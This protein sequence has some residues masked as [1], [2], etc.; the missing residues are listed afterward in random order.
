M[1]LSTGRRR[2][3]EMPPSLGVGFNPVRFHFEMDGDEVAS[4]A[5][6]VTNTPWGERHTYEFDGRAGRAG[7]ALRVSPFLGMDHEYVCH[8]SAPGEHLT[9]HVENLHDGERVF[10]A[11]L[12]L[13]RRPSGDLRRLR[14]RYPAQPLR[15]LALIYGHAALVGGRGVANRTFARCR[16]R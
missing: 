14:M 4:L 15:V 9:V 2:T 5:A 7:K 10:D 16:P 11:T 8:A 1:T 3:L 6:E 13:E 12:S